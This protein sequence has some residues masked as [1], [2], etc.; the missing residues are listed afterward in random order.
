MP[1]SPRAASALTLDLSFTGADNRLFGQGVAPVQE[2]AVGRSLV[3][4][5][6]A[7]QLQPARVR[8]AQRLAITASDALSLQGNA[9][10]REF[11]QTRRQRQHDQLHRLRAAQ[12]ACFASPTARRRSLDTAAPRSPT[13]RRRHRADRRERPRGQSTPSASAARCRRR[14]TGSLLR[15]RQS[16]RRSAPAS[17][18][19]H[20][21]FQ[22]TDG[23]RDRSTPRC[24]V[25]P[26]ACSSTR[27]RTR[28]FNATPVEP[29]RGRQIYYGLFATD[30]LQP[31]AGPGGDRE[32]ALQRRADRPAPTGCGANLTGDRPLCALQSGARDRPTSSTPDL[33]A[34][35]GYSEG[36]RAPTPSEIECSEPGAALPAALVA[37]RPIRRV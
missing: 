3:F 8:D 32:R 34:Y 14:Q 30:T 11:R 7:E 36:N 6:P 13:S 22:S 33:T 18:M 29:R 37:R 16:F 10:R 31:H 19:R 26:P 9:Y 17:T 1:I 25:Q 2:L 28:G 4:T 12:R 15:P 27:P 21:D 23:A 35:A 24:T 20:V 5:T